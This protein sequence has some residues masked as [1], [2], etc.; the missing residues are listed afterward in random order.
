ME[1]LK[2]GQELLPGQMTGF[3]KRLMSGELRDDAIVDFLTSLR[4]KGET[5]SEI[6]EAARVMREHSV[7]LSAKR[8]GLLDTC[9]TG[10]DGAG[11]FNVSTLAA[12]VAAA[13]GVPVA[14]HGNRAVSGKSG[15][16]DFLNAL[17]IRYDLEPAETARCLEATGFG[18]MFA[19]LFHPSMK[20]AASAR[21]KIRGRTLFNC[22]GPLTN[23]AGADFQLIG[24]YDKRLVPLL[25]G[26][27]GEMGSRHVIVVHGEDGL[28]EVSISGSTFVAEFDGKVESRTVDPGMLG[29]SR[30]AREALCC[31]GPEAS[32]RAAG[33]VLAGRDGPKMDFTLVNAAFALKAAGRVKGVTEGIGL[34]R[35]LLKSGAVLKTIDR[36]REFQRSLG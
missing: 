29:I 2:A 15:S 12:L 25:A 3:M 18:F 17:G 31:E 23:P 11:T 28:D 26:A 4:Q 14:K 16:A 36:I 6:V 34:A 21:K 1:R 20:H 22:L 24:V 8:E 5:V 32:V 30:A 19:P 7:K 13:A 27:L 10:G 35:Q 33:E 9:G